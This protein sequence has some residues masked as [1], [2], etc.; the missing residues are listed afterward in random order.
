MLEA[1][2]NVGWSKDRQG[3]VLGAQKG[4]KIQIS[5]KQN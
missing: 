1:A 3:H 5:L 4:T 2:L